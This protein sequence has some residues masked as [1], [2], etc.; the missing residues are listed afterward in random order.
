MGCVG[1]CMEGKVFRAPTGEMAPWGQ[2]SWLVFILLFH[3]TGNN[4]NVS[5][6]SLR[7]PQPCSWKHGGVDT[8]HLY[9]GVLNGQSPDRE[10]ILEQKDSG[11]LCRP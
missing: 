3:A 1:H 2:E 10:R 9:S 5:W 7:G 6:M 4:E 8:P 11:V